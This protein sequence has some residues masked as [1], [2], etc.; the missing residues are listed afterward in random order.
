MQIFYDAVNPVQLQTLYSTADF[1]KKGI[2]YSKSRYGI[3]QKSAFR[4]KCKTYQ[5]WESTL[6]ALSRYNHRNKDN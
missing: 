1:A 5:I 2:V 4:R 6:G 3:E